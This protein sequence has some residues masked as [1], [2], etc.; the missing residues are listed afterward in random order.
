MD[1]MLM[2]GLDTRRDHGRRQIALRL[3]QCQTC[4][5]IVRKELRQI[6]AREGLAK[7]DLRLT[8]TEELVERLAENGFDDRYGARPLQRTLERHVVSALSR[9]LI[10]HPI[11]PNTEIKLDVDDTG[12]TVIRT[13]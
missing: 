3:R 9:Y 8:F 13:D 12:E 5:E 10:D 2:A 11:P 6:A 1:G 4:R 7:T